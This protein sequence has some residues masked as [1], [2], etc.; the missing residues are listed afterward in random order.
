[1]KR[2]QVLCIFAFMLVGCGKEILPKATPPIPVKSCNW[3]DDWSPTPGLPSCE[4]LGKKP[5]QWD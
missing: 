4:A 5:P 2:I 1:M 3:A